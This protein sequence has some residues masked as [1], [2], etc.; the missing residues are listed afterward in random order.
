MRSPDGLLALASLAL[1]RASPARL[2]AFLDLASLAHLDLLLHF[3]LLAHGLLA[4][5]SLPL[6]RTSP[7]PLLAIALEEDLEEN[8]ERS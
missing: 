2:L 4:L 5:A 6:L 8:L 1:N 3:A 7:A